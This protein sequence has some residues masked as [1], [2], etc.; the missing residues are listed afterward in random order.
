MPF[1]RVGAGGVTTPLLLGT[2]VEDE[3]DFGEGTVSIE[4]RVRL[5]ESAIFAYDPNRPPVHVRLAKVVVLGAPEGASD[6][7]VRLHEARIYGIP[8]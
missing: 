7:A 5:H 1:Y 4:L 8:A 3:V 6:V 2:V